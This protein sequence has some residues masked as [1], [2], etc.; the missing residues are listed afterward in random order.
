MAN[1]TGYVQQFSLVR[2][3]LVWKEIKDLCHYL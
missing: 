3:F 2:A 1:V